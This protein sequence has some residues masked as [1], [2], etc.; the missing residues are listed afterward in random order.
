M[1]LIVLELSVY[2]FHFFQGLLNLDYESEVEDDMLPL[3]R[4]GEVGS[5]IFSDL[6][7]R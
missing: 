6:C 7:V 5:N 4:K 1:Q 2:V 3:F